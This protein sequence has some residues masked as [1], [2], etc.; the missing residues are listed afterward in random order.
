MSGDITRDIFFQNHPD[1]MLVYELAT[2]RILVVNQTFQ[3]RYGYTPD[4]LKTLRLDDLHPDD[5]LRRLESNVAAVTTG[6]DRAGIWQ[7]RLKSGELI[8]VEITSHTM[9]YDGK[10]C[11]LVVARDMT[12][13]V[14][15]EKERDQALQR[16][17][18]L[19]SRAEAAAYHFQ[20]LFESAPGKLL[21][22]EPEDYTIVA[23][24]DAYLEAVMR[25]RSDIMGKRLFDVFPD[26]PDD[27]EANG[28]AAV[29]AVMERVK[30]SGLSEALPLTRFPVERPR[31]EGGGFE[32]RWWLSVFS[33]VK[34]PDGRAQYIICR[35]EDVTGLI[36]G[37]ARDAAELA[38]ELAER[39]L[40]L[41]LMVHSRELREATLRLNEREASIRTVERLLAL[42][43]WRFDLQTQKLEW[44]DSTFRIYGLDPDEHEPDY[45]LYVSLVHPDDR[46]RMESWFAEFLVSGDRSSEFWHRIV[47]PDGRVITIRGVAERTVT[48]E[49]EATTGF[50]QDITGQLET[51]ARLTEA[52]HLLRLAGKSARFGAWRADL[53]RQV[54]EWSE[55]VAAIHDMPGTREVPV[56][57]G[58][59]FYA[60]GSQERVAE[61]FARCIETGEPYDEMLEI[62][63][64]TG[65]RVWCRSIGEAERNAA[66]EVIAV[67]GAFQDISELVSA[68]LESA[69]L[70]ERL[71]S[72][73][74]TMSDGFYLL[75]ENLCFSFV[76]EEAERA[77][78]T[79]RRHMLGKYVWDVFPE[80][81]RD[82]L[83]PFYLQARDTGQTVTTGFHYA[84]FNAWFHVRIHP[85]AG[86]LA[87]YLQDVT[88]ERQ[89]EEQLQLLQAAVRHANDVVII[90]EGEIGPEG[91]RIVYV[92]D[93]FEQVFGYTAEEVLGGST[94]MLHGPGTAPETVL[95][96]LAAIAAGQPVRTEIVHYTRSGE[97][98]WMDVDVVP[99]VDA[100]GRLTH[101]L[102]IQRDITERKQNEDELLAARDEAERANR[103]KSEFLANMSHEIRTPLN[104]VLGM[105]QLLA[106]TGLDARQTRMVETVQS[107]G[108]ALLAIINDILD[109][110]K[111]EAG[112]MTLEPETVDVDALCE[113]ALSAVRGTAQNKALALDLAIDETV[114]GHVVADRRRLA[115]VLINLLGNAVKFTEAG[116]VWLNV[117]CPDAQTIRFEVADTGPGIS[118]EQAGHIFDR[119]RQVDASYA[120][121]HEGAG[122][123]L[124]LCKEFAGLMGGHISLHSRPGE[125][126]RFAVH[127]PLVVTGSEISGPGE[128]AG[129]ASLPSGMGRIL[130]AEDNA[131][132]RQTLEMFLG[133]LGVAPPVCVTNGREAVDRA[134]AEDF[135]LIIM[136]VSMPIM[137]GLDAIREIRSSNTPR[138]DVPILALTAHAAPQDREECLQAGANDYLAKPVDLEALASA[139]SRL[140]QQQAEDV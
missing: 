84:P 79:P 134:L 112:L 21:V 127:L 4:D 52:D 61:I 7:H 54:V 125:G 23:I 80:D 108:K 3:V 33:A 136:D 59:N 27:P 93:A 31:E 60:P 62:I 45:D 29:A 66:G 28:V 120:R 8:H 15:F 135:A 130:I 131:T 81:V 39:P 139:L 121:Q 41:D 12:E 88:D 107:S 75:D 6:L 1:P 63:T 10:A 89:A 26:D 30:G 47:R 86:G 110:S 34:G 72:T 122:L 113:Q 138:R 92:N 91:P 58:I 14:R 44:S 97:G 124:A 67:R 74:N 104:G 18:A 129:N 95:E 119:F 49:G 76:N 65:R 109:L 68:R 37:Q 87:I 50:V 96:V 56:Q 43:Q 123:G 9:E 40:E 116:S 69:Q 42:G 118:P 101:W 102:A 128:E 2:R 94:R 13:L 53:K 20:S 106:R 24:S 36:A 98:R 115:Q 90:A 77:L 11:E 117:D 17:A 73:L 100:Q 133:E 32:E 140:I 132:N 22:L 35:S 57:E 111:I 71:Q 82:V 70:A 51:D 16:E 48:P 103:L 85:G 83:E 64:A 78:R 19:R 5:E 99:I 38:A 114:P 46:A 137:S 25:R 55:E 126:S 105:S